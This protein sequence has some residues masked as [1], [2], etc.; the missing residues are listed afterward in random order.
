MSAA[1]ND[2]NKKLANLQELVAWFEGDDI[3]IEEAITKFESANKLADEIRE[4]LG[5]LENKI[6]VLNERFDRDK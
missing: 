3:D 1:K 5:N 2:L 6:T 4:Q